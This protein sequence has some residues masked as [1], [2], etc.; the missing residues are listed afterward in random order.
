MTLACEGLLDRRP[1][2]LGEIIRGCLVPF[3]SPHTWM[4]TA[5]THISYSNVD[6]ISSRVIWVEGHIPRLG[7]FSFQSS[8]HG[9]CMPTIQCHGSCVC[10]SVIDTHS[11]NLS[12][13]SFLS[14]FTETNTKFHLE[15]KSPAA[16]NLLEKCIRYQYVSSEMISLIFC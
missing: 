14:L 8:P 15:K 12:L 6:F 1:C 13:D 2:A 11:F 10:G 3:I 9:P 4:E 7:R 5:L 16:V